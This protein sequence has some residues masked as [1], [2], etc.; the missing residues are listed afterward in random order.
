MHKCI[1]YLV[2]NLEARAKFQ[3]HKALVSLGANLNIRMAH[4]F[5][6]LN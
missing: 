3:I 5:V 4:L 6:V 2:I 1:I